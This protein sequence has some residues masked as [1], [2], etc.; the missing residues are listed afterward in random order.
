RHIYSLKPVYNDT[1]CN[2]KPAYN[3]NFFGPG[4][5]PIYTMYSKPPYN[6]NHFLDAPAYSDYFTYID[7]L[8]QFLSDKSLAAEGQ[9]NRLAADSAAI[10]SVGHCTNVHEPTADQESC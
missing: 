10:V 7:P 8:N 6:D 9:R 2:D 1:V 4:G 5:I 3:D